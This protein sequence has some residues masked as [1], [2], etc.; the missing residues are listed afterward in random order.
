MMGF[1]RIKIQRRMICRPVVNHSEDKDYKHMKDFDNHKENNE[2][3]VS[4]S[5]SISAKVRAFIAGLTP[6]MIF[7]Y[8]FFSTV[9]I[10]LAAEITYYTATQSIH[11]RIDKVDTA[12]VVLSGSDNLGGIGPEE[13]KAMNYSLTNNSTAPAYVFIRIEM[14]TPGLYEVVGTEN[15]E[16]DGWCRVS[17]AEG[18]GE[19]ILAYGTLGN[20]TPVDIGEEVVMS[21]RLHCLAGAEQYSGLS[22]DDMDIDVHGCLVYGTSEDGGAA[23]YNKSAGSL[24]QAYLENKDH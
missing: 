8:T 16:I 17:A 24:W 4:N 5:Y 6:G 10:A 13:Y 9:I 20:M 15:A 22:G 23:E 18:D 19:I 1:R 12:T 7:K 11:V 3:G 2:E 21:G 14:V